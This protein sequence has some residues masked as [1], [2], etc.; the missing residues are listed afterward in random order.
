MTWTLVEINTNFQAN[1]VIYDLD[2]CHC[3]YQ[4]PDLSVIRSEYV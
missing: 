2:G 4:D 3:V 1:S